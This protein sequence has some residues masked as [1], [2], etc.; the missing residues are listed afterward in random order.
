MDLNISGLEDVVEIGRGGFATVHR[1]YQPA[2]RRT[3]AVKVL[4]AAC[5]DDLSIERFWRECQAMGLSSGHP[6]I[7]TALDAGFLDS[8]QAYVVMPYMPAGSLADRVRRDGP[9]PWAEASIVAVKLAGALHAAHDSGVI[10]SDMKPANVLV[11]E[12]GEPKLADFGIARISGASDTGPGVVTAS[13]AFAPPEVIEGK[14]PTV[15][16]DIYSLGTTIYYLLSGHAPFRVCGET[17]VAAILSRIL[18]DEPQDVVDQGVPRQFAEVVMKAMSKNPDDRFETAADFGRHVRLAQD[19]LGI[20]ATELTIFR[21]QSQEP[22]AQADVSADLLTSG[23]DDVEAVD[24]A[25]EA[26]RA[27]DEVTRDV[28]QVAAGG[29][30]PAKTDS[31]QPTNR[32]RNLAIAGALAVLLL[33][34][35]TTVLN[36]GLLSGSGNTREPA[37]FLGQSPPLDDPAASLV[38]EGYIPPS[39]GDPLNPPAIS[40]YGVINPLQNAF[41]HVSG[42]KAQCPDGLVRDLSGQDLSG[43]VWRERD[44]RCTDFRGADLSGADLQGSLMW[45]S[46]FTGVD[47][48]QVNFGTEMVNLQA[49]VLVGADLSGQ[50]MVQADWGFANLSD[51]NLMGSNLDMDEEVVLSNTICADGSNSDDTGCVPSRD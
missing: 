21:V 36:R 5:L 34:G 16:S 48:T 39:G 7:V 35:L 6:N 13:L 10:H 31:E 43:V 25:D 42:R 38:A 28:P 41:D 26:D 45:G 32:R 49:A 8:G 15:R 37:R 51:A 30:S 22:A 40:D 14:R 46:D 23:D 19:E 18:N 33:M 20:R 27:D 1:A 24:G 44:L 47:L 4:N 17:S 50:V 3:V 29:P 2:F 11:S 12:Y 9:M